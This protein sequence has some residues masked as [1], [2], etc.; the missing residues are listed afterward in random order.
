MGLG[1]PIPDLS[2]KPGPGR[3]GWGPIGSYDFQFEVTGAVT[4]KANAAATGTFRISWPNGTT[5]TYS[6]DNASIAAPDGTAG[7]V[8]INNEELD[9]TYADEFSVVGGQTNVSKVISWG[10]NPWSNMTNAFSGCTSLSDISTT[11]FISSTQGDMV[12][13]FNGCT[14]LLEADIRNWDLTA[15][16][17]W[18]GGSPFRGLVNLQK[19][20]AT[21]LNVKLIGR[22]DSSF[23]GIGTAVTDGCEFL[24][25]GFNMSTS[26]ATTTGGFLSGSRI[27][28]TSDF[29]N[30]VFN[31]N[32][33]DGGAMFNSSI[34]TGAN[35]TLNCSGWSTY[36]GSKLPY[37]NTFNFNSAD[38]NATQ[39][40]PGTKIDFTNL[41][42]SSV[43]Y[44][45]S[46]YYYTGISE[47]IGLS[48]WGATAGNVNMSNMFVGSRFLKF[49]DSDNFNSTFINSLTPSNVRQAFYGVGSGLTSG[50][51]VA[52]N[53]TNIDLSNCTDFYSMFG[54]F[55]STNVPAINTA[56]FPSTAINLSNSFNGA[57]FISSSETHIDFSNT[58]IKINN[59]RQM[60][61]S[62]WVESYFW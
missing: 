42:V 20:D 25:S 19:L 18:Y 47:I 51:G 24:M 3:P 50:Y 4:V 56:T 13:M 8:S 52:P 33:F 9:T 27:K 11:S 38:N 30:W 46:V 41:N 40:F 17:D 12:T 21:G 2:N 43:S 26:T 55:R 34:L 39:L 48:T 62:T 1:M 15:G 35:S 22:A 5:N 60:F 44:A 10:K 7:I 58:T 29:S 23:A 45:L 28:P 36:S 14:S 59:T 54:G 31:P 37:F 6:G 32:G 57:R 53:I 49:S 16:A 61:S